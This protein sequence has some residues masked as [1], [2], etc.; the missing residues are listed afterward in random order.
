MGDVDRLTKS[1]HFLSVKTTFTMT[2]YTELYIREIFR[3]HGI[4]V[5]IVSDRDT[6]F[7]SAVRRSLHT[8]LGTKLQFSIAFQPQ[9]DGQTERVNRVLEDL[10]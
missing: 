3:L 8:S 10:L 6:R 1:T 7:T 5:P 9:T 4:P 2:Q